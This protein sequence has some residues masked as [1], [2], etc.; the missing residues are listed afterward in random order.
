MLFYCREQQPTAQ[1]SLPETTTYESIDPSTAPS[2]VYSRIEKP[3]HDYENAAVVMPV[4]S[5]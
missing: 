1:T 5:N 4:Y 2:V 3:E